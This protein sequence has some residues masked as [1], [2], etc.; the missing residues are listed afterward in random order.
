MIKFLQINVGNN[1][2]ATE[3]AL[4][5]LDEFQA[6]VIGLQEPF[7]RTIREA[8]LNNF[9]LI[10]HDQE[11][12]V[13][14]ALLIRNRFA[15]PVKVTKYTNEWMS[16]VLLQD[17]GQKLVIASVYCNLKNPGNLPRNF[18]EDLGLLEQ[19]LAEFACADVVIMAD[20]NARHQ[21]F[22]DHVTNTRGKEFIRFVNECGVSIHNNKTDRKPTFIKKMKNGSLRTSYIDF[23]LTNDRA[24]DRITNWQMFTDKVETEP[25]LIYFELSALNSCDF[26]S[27]RSHRFNFKKIDFKAMFN[28]FD[29]VKPELDTV[30]GTDLDQF[31][32]GLIESLIQTCKIS[33][34]ES[35]CEA[36]QPKKTQPWFTAKIQKMRN[37]IERV[38]KFK[39]R[40]Q[41]GDRRAVIDQHLKLLNKNFKLEV[42]RAKENYR[43]RTNRIRNKDDVFK[44][45]RKCKSVRPETFSTFRLENGNE[46]SD[47]DDITADI[48][49]RF[50]KRRAGPLYTNRSSNT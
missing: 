47:L 7:N 15:R 5:R 18:E 44:L 46:S 16:T 38:L 21:L 23:I 20:A 36:K 25:N 1:E 11:N 22:G 10:I 19:L 17:R 34:P 2:D 48:M 41:N 42:K 32:L 49:N 37:E 6:E 35:G 8:D 33:T 13:K 24:K 26:H 30:D 4:Q 9:E 28:T 3:G 29:L 43:T 12:R 31:G 14:A 45:T 27:N 40:V 50:F 39:K